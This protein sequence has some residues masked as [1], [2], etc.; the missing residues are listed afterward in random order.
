MVVGAMAQ[1]NFTIVRPADGAKIRETVRILFPK[2]SVPETGGYIGIF[3]GGKFIEAVRPKVGQQFL[4]YELN[5]KYLGL[6]DGQIDLE[7]VL[8]QDFAD[9]PR[10]VD[11]SSVQL[12]VQNSASIAIPQDGLKIRYNFR[13]GTQWVY[14]VEQRMAVNTLSEAMANQGDLRDLLVGADV[15]TMRMLYSVENSYP[16]GEGLV[17]MQPMPVKGKDNLVVS[18]EMSPEP[19]KYEDYQMAPIYMRLKSDGT[20][21]FGS[22]P[23]YFPLDG[24]TGELQRTDLF[25]IF[26]LPVL[27]S[28]P[29]RPGSF[30]RSNFQ[31]G[32]VDLEKSDELTAI[33]SK[34]GITARG[35]LV[36]VEWEMGHPCARIRHTLENRVPNIAGIPAESR[37]LSATKVQEDIFFALDLGTVIKMTREFTIDTKQTVQTGGGGAAGAA[38]TPGAGPA[39]NLPRRGAAQGM[40]LGHTDPPRI[41]IKQ[42]PGAPGLGGP[43]QGFGQQMGGP[44]GPPGMQVPGRG[45]G[46][47]TTRSNSTRIVRVTV[48]QAFILEK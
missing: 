43:P 29:Q 24:S 15:E 25:A 36:S 20:E 30:W 37:V 38:G 35:D 10:I 28:Q 23:K 44:G 21:V 5:T 2:N 39:A 45:P 33:T 14:R 32:A 7:A 12:T 11:R 27:P 48:Q 13:P 17:R 22:I 19:K 34:G 40:N 16:G 6:P 3:I 46:G 47:S 42:R 8:Y 4:Y 18:T 41:D 31:V 1:S 26:P 9:R